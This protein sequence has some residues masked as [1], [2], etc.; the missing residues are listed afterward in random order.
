MKFIPVI[1]DV[2]APVPVPSLVL[3]DKIIV[4]FVLVLQ[5]TPRT[6]TLAPP[7]LEIFPPLDALVP[8]KEEITDEV[9]IGA[10]EVVKVTSFP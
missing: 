5:I 1:E 10:V 6:V 9:R 4:G 8:V 2:N 3:V 7:S